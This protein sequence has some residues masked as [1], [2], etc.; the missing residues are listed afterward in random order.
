MINLQ[1]TAADANGFR[2]I[3]KRPVTQK[4]KLL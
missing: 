2:S 3:C 1:A 4:F